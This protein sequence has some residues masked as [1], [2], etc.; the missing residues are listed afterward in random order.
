[1]TTHAHTL[2]RS[3][4]SQCFVCVCVCICVCECVFGRGRKSQVLGL[5]HSATGASEEGPRVRDRGCEGGAGGESS[6]R[7]M[8]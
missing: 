7:V 4:F 6:T 5:I 1:M 8:V 2:G 3:L